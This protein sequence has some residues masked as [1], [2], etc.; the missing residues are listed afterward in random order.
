PTEVFAVRIGDEEFSCTSGHMF[1]VSG[2]GWT[3]TRHLEDGAPIHAAA[4]VER[5]VGVESYGREEPVYNLVVA[6]W[7]SYFV[8]DSAVL[9][10]DVTS[11]EPTL[12]VVPGLLQTR[13]DRG[14]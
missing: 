4:G 2:R 1:W 12:A 6:D 7:H 9:T 13:L 5:V 8:G 3:M 11:K 14:R 10:H